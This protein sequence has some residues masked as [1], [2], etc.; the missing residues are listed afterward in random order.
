MLTKQTRS[1]SILL[2]I[3]LTLMYIRWFQQPDE[4]SSVQSIVFI[5]L[6]LVAIGIVLLINRID[7][8]QKAQKEG[9]S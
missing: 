5:I 1:Y 9:E 3:V 6:M 2:Y 7:S 4:A 8:T